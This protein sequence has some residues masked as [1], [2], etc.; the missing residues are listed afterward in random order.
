MRDI[1]LLVLFAAGA[2]YAIRFAWMGI[3]MS[4]GISLMSPHVEFGHAAA[5]WPVAQVIVAATLVGLLRTK[6]RQSPFLGPP[7]TWL[8]V[9]VLWICITLPMS[10]YFELSLPLWVRS[11]KI[12]FLVY[13]TLMLITD[14]HKLHV[15]IIVIVC[16]LAFYG[17]KG[18]LFTL[19]TG[20]NY[21]V[22]GPGGFVEGN[23]ELAVALMMMLPMVR[24]LHLQ[25]T[26]KW[27]RRIALATLCLLPVTILGSH[28][29]GALLALS[30]GGLFLWLR[31]EKKML[32]AV[33]IVGGAVLAVVL[34]P[35]AYWSRMETIETY[36]QDTSAMTRINAWWC[37]F[38]VAKTHVF[39]GGF[40]YYTWD[41]IARYAPD[42]TSL[43]GPHSI[44]FQIMG[45]HGFIG[46]F[47]FLGI[48]ASTW[49]TCAAMRR[50]AR[51]RPDLKWVGDLGSM[52]QVSMI[53]FAVGG[54]FLGLAY[55][56]L[57]YYLMVAAVVGLHVAR[58][59]PAP[60]AT[61]AAPPPAPTLRRGL[62][63]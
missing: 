3:V 63:R 61:V 31:G 29:R 5:S 40:D 35:A 22:W 41:V 57:P 24:Y 52:I 9:F 7:V 14:K 56:D 37:A 49:F 10:M 32:G 21:R 47:L 16:A 12:Y 25:A 50:E 34:M 53:G 45:E 42:P 51:G 18:G 17:V 26:S 8:T 6:E 20:G 4:A 62:S 46:L 43:Q 60:A 39:G 23:N 48:G 13:L 19:A 59:Q 30:A 44:Y 15:F 1:V 27:P 11:I 38:N 54:A 58:R 2:V 36:N 28:S 33:L 55:F